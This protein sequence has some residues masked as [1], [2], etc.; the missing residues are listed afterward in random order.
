MKRIGPYRFI[1]PLATG[2]FSQVALVAR[3][4]EFYACKIIDQKT[5]VENEEEFENEIRIH[6]KLDHPNIVKL[7]DLLMDDDYFYLIME[8]CSHGDLCDFLEEHEFCNEDTTKSIAQQALWALQYLQSM[9]ISHRDIKPENFLLDS[10]YNVKLTDFGLSGIVDK[11]GMITKNCGSFLYASPECLSTKKYNGM[12]TDMWSLGVTLFTLLNGSVPW[13]GKDEEAVI[14]QIFNEDIK[15][16]VFVSKSCADF[17]KRLMEKDWTKR[18]TLEE[19]LNHPWLTESPPLVKTRTNR[20]NTMNPEN[21]YLT[22]EK[23]E[24]FLKKM[25]ENEIKRKI[26]VVSSNFSLENNSQDILNQENSY[27]NTT[28]YNNLISAAKQKNVHDKVIEIESYKEETNPTDEQI[29][30]ILQFMSS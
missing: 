30:K 11:N 4:G 13:I 21:E 9:N 25:K 22:S 27:H 18:M 14:N 23:V 2:T 7:V 8:Y 6:Q 20:R 24:N 10:L 1:K 28:F 15:L 26:H 5:I 3:R 12:A 19:A 29:V 16:P 17:I